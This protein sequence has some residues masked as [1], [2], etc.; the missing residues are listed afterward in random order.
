M[1]KI[2]TQKSFV[3]SGPYEI[4]WSMIFHAQLKVLFTN[5]HIK[6]ELEHEIVLK[7]FRNLLARVEKITLFFS[8]HSILV[9][10]GVLDPVPISLHTRG[11]IRTELGTHGARG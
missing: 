9:P 5:L 3:I 7:T 8:V 6:S 2:R 4:F 1:N 11:E 10:P